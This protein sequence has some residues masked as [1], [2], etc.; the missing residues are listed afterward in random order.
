VSTVRK[1]KNSLG[2]IAI[3][4]ALAL[5]CAAVP[6]SA[7][8]VTRDSYREAVEPIC[9]VNARA[10][11]KILGGVRKLVRKGKLKPASIQFTKAAKAL[12]KTIAQLK[13]VP[14]PPADQAR[15]AKWLRFVS[16]EAS[17]LNN[18]A[19]KL[20]QGNKVG[21]QAK[22]IRLEH[23]ASLANNVAVPFEFEYC[24]FDPSRFT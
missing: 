21:A 23:N 14:Q 22:V 10:N 9:K 18:V 6:A 3:F 11:E 8:E 13:T 20:K 4:A 7:G 16:T 15:L 24:R 1:R 19:K 12:R 2:G 17:L 5:L